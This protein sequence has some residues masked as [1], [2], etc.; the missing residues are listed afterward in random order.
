[1]PPSCY[2]HRARDLAPPLVRHPPPGDFGDAGLPAQALLDL[3]RVDV[4]PAGDEHVRR[5]AGDVDIAFVV[6]HAEV[7]GAEP[8]V[9]E[10][11]RVR[12][13]VAQISGEHRR[14]GDTDLALLAGWQFLAVVRLNAHPHSRA[15]I[16]TRAER[17]T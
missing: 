12:F 10:G 3:P 17:D 16:A 13:V 2:T 14:P 8:A 1:R 6:D 5:P 4:R 11:R 7:T 15:R 9:A